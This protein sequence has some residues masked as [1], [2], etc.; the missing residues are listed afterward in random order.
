MP[1]V[2]DLERRALVRGDAVLEPRRRD[3]LRKGWQVRV[4]VDGV[5]HAT[6]GKAFRQTQR[7]I[8][9]RGPISTMT[10]GRRRWLSN[11]KKR[12]CRWPLHIFGM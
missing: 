5:D 12:P 1:D 10:F 8:A 9:C 7:A 2:D 3:V 6:G 11:D 4:D